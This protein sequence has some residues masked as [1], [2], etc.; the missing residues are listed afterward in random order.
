MTTFDIPPPQQPKKP[1]KKEQ[2]QLV[3]YPETPN[4][5]DDTAAEVKALSN[6]FKN[7]RDKEKEAKDRNTN[8][9]Y[10]FAV[11]FQDE[12]QKKEFFDKIG[13]TPEISA[14]Q[15]I[16]GITLAKLLGIEIVKKEVKKPG[17]FREFN[18]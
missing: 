4:I 6:Q 5:F 3:D 10:W 16:D 7:A 13:V 2:E 14:G 8:A 15:Y 12:D 11:Y 18:L 9:A 1:T 17:K